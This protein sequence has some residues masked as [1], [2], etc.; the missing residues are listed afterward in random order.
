MLGEMLLVGAGLL[1]GPSVDTVY[2]GSAGALRV[3]APRVE[4]PQV[5]V[6]GRLDE[7]VW[8]EAAVLS[9]FTQFA[10]AEGIPASQSTEVR[11]W[12]DGDALY[13]GITAHDTDAGG[14]RATLTERDRGVTDDDWVRITLDTFNDNSQAYAFYVN[15]RGVQQD[16]L[17][18]EGEE[19]RFGPPIDFATDFLW[20][21]DARVTEEGWVAE[22]RIPFVSLRFPSA[23]EQTWGLNVAR[24]IRRVEYVSSWAPLTGN[25]A[26]QLALS[27]RL[28]GLEGLQGRRLVELNPVATGKRTGELDDDG[29]FVR[30]GFE[31]ALGLNARYGLTRNLVVDAT[32]NPDF[33]QVEADA[34]QVVVNERF[35]LFFPEKRPF[36]L[37]GME[38]FNTPQRLVYTRA[39][40]DPIGGAKLTGK[41]GRV[42]VGYLGAVDESP[43][44][45]DQGDAEAAFNL[46]RLRRDVGTASTVGAL[47]TDRTLVDGSAH[48][49]TGS[50][51]TRLVLGGRYTLTAQL[52]G[53]WSRETGGE[54]V[55]DG[56]GGSEPTRDLFGSLLSA[57]LSRSGRVVSWNVGIEDV[58]PE[59]RARSGFIRR[60][61]DTQVE[62]EIGHSFRRPPGAW[63]ENWTPRLEI[64]A[65][66]DHDDFWAGR[67][68][69]EAEVE[70]GLNV[71][72]R[73]PNGFVLFV[74]QG[75]FAFD[76]ADYAGYTIPP[77]DLPFP[78]DPDP[79]DPPSFEPEP[80]EDLRGVTLFGRTRPLPW[81]AFNGR[82]SYGEVPIYAE[83]TRGVELALSPTASIRVPLGFFADLSFTYSRI[84]R[85][86]GEPFSRA[87]IPR[88]RI[89]YQLTRALF[90]RGIVQYNLQQRDALRTADGEPLILP[91]GPSESVESGEF[92]YDL[93]AS[94]EPSP[95]TIVYAGW[96]RIREGPQTYRFG[97]LTP[98]AEGLFVKVSYLLR[99]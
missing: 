11:V 46:L 84:R 23:A 79:L 38:V 63:L 59:F 19:F 95:G 35:A 58:H 5:R 44:T 34:D 72:L 76:P 68:Y 80:L 65:A 70:L 40:V 96:S 15:P 47:Y 21:S 91:G 18:L 73:G 8:S 31:P 32:I 56:T 83:G 87:Q 66:Y 52:A 33:S 75:Y 99:L 71:S 37:E 74:R 86:D 14:I 28:V 30:S 53:A 77:D 24:E 88:A 29:R 41:V 98:T 92:Q 13:F 81:L 62:A 16:G 12:Y 89:Q 25:A 39:I 94:Y 97:D 27:G 7:P 64:S 3:R 26:N 85:V 67:R 22:V 49:R 48:N 69:Q 51:D 20:E 50:L 82:G 57:Q 60:I 17:W 6:D 36:F 1:A 55:D 42:K 2:D 45:F 10:P 9:G 54:P 78:L 93:L 90:V 4:S 61:G 43:V